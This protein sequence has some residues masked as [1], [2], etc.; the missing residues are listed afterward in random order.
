M[1][2]DERKEEARART[3]A[4]SSSPGST[5]A[6]KGMDLFFLQ[7]LNSKVPY[8]PMVPTGEEEPTIK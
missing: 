3:L 5:A 1:I 2:D 7:N 4:K 6:L 8:L